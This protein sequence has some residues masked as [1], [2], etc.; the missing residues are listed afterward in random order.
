MQGGNEGTGRGNCEVGT[1]D[2]SPFSVPSPISLIPRLP[3]PCF[4]FPIPH[5]RRLS[6]LVLPSKST[7]VHTCGITV[8]NSV[9]L[10]SRTGRQSVTH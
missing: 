8:C 3:C 7:A 5:S 4:P 1:G 6:F 10:D 9:C 2:S